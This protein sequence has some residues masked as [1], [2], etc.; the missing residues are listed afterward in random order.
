MQYACIYWVN[1]FYAW[2]ST[3][4]HS[5][6]L[7]D[8]AYGLLLSFFKTECLYWFEAMSLL[9]HVT[10]TIKAVQKLKRL[11]SNMLLVTGKQYHC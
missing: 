2:Y 4:S 1:H 6:D 8:S 7:D 11:A 5:P 3:E 10:D 9:R